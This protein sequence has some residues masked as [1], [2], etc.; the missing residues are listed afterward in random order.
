MRLQLRWYDCF[1]TYTISCTGDPA[2]PLNCTVFEDGQAEEA[3]ISDKNAMVDFSMANP[4]SA[5]AMNHIPD[6]M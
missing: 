6:L 2:K 4:I 1:H 3:T 5:V